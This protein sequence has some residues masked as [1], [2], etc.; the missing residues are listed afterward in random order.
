MRCKIPGYVLLG[1]FI[2]EYEDEEDGGGRADSKLP[3]ALVASDHT[4]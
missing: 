1:E 2:F 3:N 4:W